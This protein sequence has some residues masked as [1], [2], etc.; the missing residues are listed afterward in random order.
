ML[1]SQFHISAINVQIKKIHCHLNFAG[2]IMY[3]KYLLI[4]C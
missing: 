1:N 4:I 2:D 3:V